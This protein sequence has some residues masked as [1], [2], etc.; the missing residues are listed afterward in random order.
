MRFNNYLTENLTAMGFLID[1]L[2]NS[3]EKYDEKEFI[4]NFHWQ[5]GID[6]KILKRMFI[7]Y[8]KIPAMKRFKNTPND[9][10]KWIRKYKTGVK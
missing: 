6:R 10:K 9:W 3:V 8:W 5:L 1:Q 7:D 4:E 2:A